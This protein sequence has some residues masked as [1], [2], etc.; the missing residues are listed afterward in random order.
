MGPDFKK[1]CIGLGLPDFWT[2][3]QRISDEG[4][5]QELLDTST[6]ELLQEFYWIGSY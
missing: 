6:L 1:K 5:C 4:Y 2:F 3:Y